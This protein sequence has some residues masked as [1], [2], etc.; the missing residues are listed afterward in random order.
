MFFCYLGFLVMIFFILQ[1]VA[2]LTLLERHLLGGSQCRI[3]PNKVGYGGVLQALMDGFKLIKKEQIFL[4]VSNS[5]FFFIVPCFGFVVM[6]FFWFSLP[7]FFVFFDFDYSGVFLLCLLAFSV[8]SV[9]LSGIFS[10]SLY[11]FLG[12][13]RGCS[14]SFSYEIAFSFFILF[15][16][17]VGGGLCLFSGFSFLFFFLI[18]YFFVLVLIDLHRAPFDFSECEGELVSGFNVEYSSVGFAVLFLSEYGNLI[19]FSV[20]MS[21]F[22]F[23]LSFLFFYVL[24]LCIVFCRSAYPRYRFDKLMNMCWFDFFPFGAYLLFFFC[25]VF[26]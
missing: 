8:F 1:A 2:F 23:N 13:L 10:G 12:G 16:V 4:F 24:V 18:F 26:F 9:M 21:S 5:I 17:F 22:F 15:F 7:Y 3:G 25:F 14:Q 6:I 11:S 20:L 19:F